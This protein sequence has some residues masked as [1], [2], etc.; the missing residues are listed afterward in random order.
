MKL[1]KFYILA[2]ISVLFASCSHSNEWKVKGK[3]EGAEGKTLVLE[4]SSNGYWYALDSVKLKNSGSFSF[5]EKALPYPDIFRLKVDNQT[6]YFP[7]DSTETLNIDA[8]MENPGNVMISGSE[9]AEKLMEAEQIISKYLTNSD[10]KTIAKNRELKRE[11]SELMLNNP[12]SIV[13]YYILNKKIG[14]IS[15]FDSSDKI[16]LRIIGAVANA[17]DNDRPNDPRTKFLKTIF[18]SNKKIDSSGVKDTLL[19]VEIPIIE[20]ALYDYTGKELSL[21][22]TANNNKVVVLSFTQ[23]A[24]D[25]SPAYNVELNRIYEK[26]H[27]KGLEIYQVSYDQDD[28]QWRQSAKNLPWITV[29]NPPTRNTRYLMDYNISEIPSTFII[30]NGELTDKVEDITNLDKTVGKYF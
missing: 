28:Y 2:A 3:I 20:I 11:L 10:N 30:H 7:I 18:L 5:A 16:D 15:L 25:F 8:N 22:E 9:S 4:A 17:Y 24:A 12:G 14:G 21:T 26:Y 19:A 6:I 13:A 1:S 23:Y 29:F 27:N